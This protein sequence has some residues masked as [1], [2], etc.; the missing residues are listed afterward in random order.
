[1]K[2]VYS[3][4]DDCKFD[5]VE[6]FDGAELPI[7]SMGRFCGSKLPSQPLI[8]TDNKITMKFASDISVNNKGFR[9]VFQ[10]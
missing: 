1:M 5:Y 3:E 6:V 8:A 7:N 9:A 4:D 10:G 2:F